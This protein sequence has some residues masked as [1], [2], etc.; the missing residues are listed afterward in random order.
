[1]IIPILGPEGW[2]IRIGIFSIDIILYVIWD[3]LEPVTD[4]NVKRMG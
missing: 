3:L 2:C 1:M 4:K